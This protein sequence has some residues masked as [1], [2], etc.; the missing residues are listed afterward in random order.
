MTA[1]GSLLSWKTGFHAL[2][3]IAFERQKK[4]TRSKSVSILPCRFRRPSPPSTSITLRQ[5]SLTSRP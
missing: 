2:D 5:R 1:E 4:A 3:L